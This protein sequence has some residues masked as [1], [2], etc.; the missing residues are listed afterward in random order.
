MS[1]NRRPSVSTRMWRF[2][3]LIFFPASKPCRSMHAPLFRAFDALAVDDRGAGAGLAFFAVSARHIE[4]V[5]DAFQSAVPTPQL[6]VVVNR[7]AWWQV[8]R[9]RPP[10]AACTQNV[11]N[12]VHHFAHIDMP[13]VAAALGR[14]DLWCHTGPLLVGQVAGVS[15]SAAVITS[16]ILCRPHR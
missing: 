8:F 11:Q 12:A 3:P 7:T 4:R 5:M 14:R 6:E 16:T 1:F 15:Q 13:L 10:L 9:N 2:L